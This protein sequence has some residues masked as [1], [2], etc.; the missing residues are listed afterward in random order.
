MLWNN[1]IPFNYRYVV[2][3]RLDKVSAMGRQEKSSNEIQNKTSVFSHNKTGRQEDLFVM[4]RRHLSRLNGFSQ[5]KLCHFPATL[6]R[7]TRSRRR[8]RSDV[9]QWSKESN[10]EMQNEKKANEKWQ[11]G[12]EKWFLF[13]IPGTLIRLCRMFRCYKKAEQCCFRANKKLTMPESF[14]EKLN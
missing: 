7:E 11:P 1:I 2:Y 4:K 8:S 13:Y 10:G 6:R 3:L 12:N 14:Q 5:S 9:L